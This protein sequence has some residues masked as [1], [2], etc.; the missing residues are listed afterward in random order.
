MGVSQRGLAIA[1]FGLVVI[2]SGVLGLNHWR[3]RPSA[4]ERNEGE[5]VGSVAGALSPLKLRS[6]AFADQEEIPPRYTCDGENVNPPLEI[7]NVPEMAKSLALL[8]EDMDT[9]TG[10]FWHWFVGNIDPRLGF[11]REN[12]IP[13]GSFLGLND[14]SRKAYGGPCPPS[15]RHRYLFRLYALDKE[16][17]FFA[18]ATKRELTELLRNHVL[19]QTALTGFYRR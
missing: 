17:P 1:L 9:P 11:I 8:V 5:K 7:G 18:A 10:S 4:G 6:P 13:G 19:A 12:N 2:L 15:G 16:L 3:K 14:F